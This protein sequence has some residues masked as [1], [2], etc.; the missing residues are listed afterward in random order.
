LYIY[1]WK[2]ANNILFYNYKYMPCIINNKHSISKRPYMGRQFKSGL[3]ALEPRILFDAAGI[4]DISPEIVDAPIEDLLSY[5]Q[6][7]APDDGF[8]DAFLPTSAANDQPAEFQG[9]V[10]QV[11]TNPVRFVENMGQFDTQTDFAA[12]GTGY[13]MR[14]NETELL[15]SL[16]NGST[17]A[18][19]PDVLR[20][21]W[22]GGASE[23]EIIPEQQL[24][25][26]S[27]YYHGE[28][29]QWVE[30]A[31]NYGALRYNDVY[32]GVDLLIYGINGDRLEYDFELE[33]GVD[34]GEI[35]VLFTG[36]NSLDLDESGNLLIN[37]TEGQL[38]QEAPFSYQLDDDGNRVEIDSAFIL[39]QE[40]NK[41]QFEIGEYDSNR[42]LWIDPALTYSTYFGGGAFDK[43]QAIASGTDGSIYVTGYTQSSNFTSLSAYDGTNNGSD[44]L[45]ISKF[46]SSYNLIFSTYLGG[47]NSD[48]GQ[49]IAVDSSGNAYISGYSNGGNFPRVGSPY[50]SATN[51][52][53]D[54]VAAKLTSTGSLE[55]SMGDLGGSG[56]DY[57]TGLDIDDSGNLYIS[58]YTTS[59]DFPIVNGFQTSNNGN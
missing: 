57:G 30:N 56:L 8:L 4:A 42:A 9:T 41:I 23:A 15:F 2:F 48:I 32:D 3:T 22:E 40:E 38:I 19:E 59:T 45:F 43:A 49:G 27:H 37:L 24:S 34:P 18:T 54:I 52:G 5:T 13:E 10:E 28:P 51:G 44:D 55:W 12:Q 29:D 46:D 53:G 36:A 21:S 11:N 35:S 47:T 7:G 17:E 14:M 31:E 25:S 16:W 20:M 33:A 1:L 39:D 6:E 26:V 50:Q 58:G